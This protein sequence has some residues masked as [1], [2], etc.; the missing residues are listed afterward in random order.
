MRKL[1]IEK[2]ELEKL[3]TIKKKTIYQIARIYNCSPA[4]ISK[5]LKE[6][7]ITTW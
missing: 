2:Q 4:L 7:K 6:N 3:Y 1:S 5:R